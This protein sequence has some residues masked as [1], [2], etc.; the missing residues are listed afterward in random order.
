MIWDI[1]VA[2]L[3]DA[4]LDLEAGVS[5]FVETMPSDVTVGVMLRSPLSGVR[6][7]QYLPGYYKPVL[8]VIVRHTD[9]VL[10]ETLAGKVNDALTIAGEES[11]PQNADRGAV[12]LKLFCPR[13]LPIRFPRMDGGTVEW[14][15]SFLSAF[16]LKRRQ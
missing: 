5:L 1:M 8:Q 12:Q 11:Y 9:P 16:T 6:I 3:L 4:N 10:G 2:K 14:S 13:E 15:T 7:D